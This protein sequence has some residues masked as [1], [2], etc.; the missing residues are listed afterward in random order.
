MYA[1]LGSVRV[2]TL[3]LCSLVLI[4]FWSIPSLAQVATGGITGTI[5]DESGAAVPSAALQLT[6]IGTG[7]T[8]AATTGSG[9]EFTFTL[10]PPGNYEIRT[11]ASGFGTVVQQNVE[12]LVNEITSLSITLKPSG[13]NTVVQVSSAAPPLE[14]QSAAVSGVV[15]HETISS[16]PLNGRDFIQL[17]AL[18][19]GAI[20][21]AK[22][23]NGG[24]SYLT[25]LF[26]GNYV[27]NGAPSDGSSFLLDGIEMRDTNDTRVGFEMTVDAIEEFNFQALNYS[28]AYGA[29]SGGVVN[30]SS[31]S[32]TDQ[33]HGSGWEFLRNDAFDGT[34]YFSTSK[35][36]FRQNQFGGAIGGPIIKD[37]MF[38]FASYEGF[39]RIEG[40]NR[41]VSV[42]TV[43]QRNGDFSADKPIYDPNSLDPSTGLR[44]QFAGNQIPTTMF[45]QVA[46]NALNALYPLPNRPGEV[47][48]LFATA[49]QHITS[50]QVNGRIDDRLGSSDSLFGRWTWVRVN[51]LIPFYVAGGLP[52][53]PQVYDDPADNFVLSE[54][55]N[56]SS[57]TVNQA[58]IGYNRHVQ[59][60]EDSQ[61]HVPIDQQLGIT[62]TSAQY[63]GNPSITVSGLGTTGV[64]SNAPNDRKDNDYSFLDNISHVR[65]NHIF[66]MGAKLVFEQVNGQ[67]TPSGHGSF[68]F[69]GTFTSQLSPTGTVA[70]TG[71]AFA[72]FLLGYPFSSAR[73]CVAGSPHHNNR[74]REIGTYFEDDWKVRS[75]LT[76]N[77]GIRWDYF[78]HLYDVN[79]HFDFP[80]ITK[81]PNL[82]LLFAGQN[83]VS[84]SIAN[85]QYTDFA[86]RFGLAYTL[87]SKTVI[88]AGYGIFFNPTSMVYG[89]TA[90]ID[91]PF[92][93]Q[94]SFTSSKITPQLTLANAFPAALAVASSVYTGWNPN[95]ADPY[96]QAW[97]LSIARDLGHQMILTA[98]YVGNKGTHEDMGAL[99]INAPPPGPGPI[100]ARRPIPTISN[101]SLDEDIGKSIYHGLEIKGEKHFSRG[102]GF[103]A[104]YTY[105]KCIDTGSIGSRYD[106]ADGP[107]RNPFNLAAARGLCDNDERNRF[108]AN[109]LYNLPFGQGRSGLPALLIAG[110]RVEGILT[111]DAGQPF[112]VLLPNDNSNTGRLQDYPDLVPGQN[113]N[114]GPRTP[115]EWFNV[116]AFQEPTPFTFGDAL[117]NMT[118]GPPLK[119]LDFSLTK[120]FRITERQ[121]IQ[122][123]TEAFNILNH[124]NFF[125]PGRVFGTPSFGVIGAA[126]DP[127]EIQFA[128]KY[129]F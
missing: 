12:V 67:V 78:G 99:N 49:F 16:L 92:V 45:S 39:R 109:A 36:A 48:N 80:D 85:P 125:Q 54:T 2:K 118:I 98:T 23:P 30:I 44:A 115:I 40:I 68:T 79:N 19:P 120:D 53:F 83:G 101:V 33:F 24:E 66:T 35:P 74:R 71:N 81:A 93:D 87:H 11:A 69:N 105:S 6:E 63:L 21:T 62:G 128:L 5:V 55:H 88:R 124:A 119:N 91:P 20:P 116:N 9:G 106:G 32:G 89:V 86:P 13:V 29:A 121:S 129:M 34:N 7:A 114:N 72:D 95:R 126:F 41:A 104:S 70:G 77:M 3:L 100:Q 113:P 46:V 123:R 52:N 26:G 28:A 65:G 31:R 76:L 56:F 97:N 84:R 59:K 8:R 42:P 102:L 37:K 90:G 94:S 82:V 58:E 127:R 73:C 122:F 57:N 103:L 51:R 110:W 22:L 112:S 60:A 38:F 117:R 111:L 96:S 1:S 47:N 15:E 4:Y 108:V 17:V 64:I 50:D 61:Q 27:V 14:T 107:G 43:A 18:Q 25:T 75:N 10:L